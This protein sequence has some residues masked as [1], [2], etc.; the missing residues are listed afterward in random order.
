MLLYCPI[1]KN[2]ETTVDVYNSV[3]HKLWCSKLSC[4]IIKKLFLNTINHRKN[5]A[6]YNAYD[7]SIL[8]VW[9]YAS[10][11]LKMGVEFSCKCEAALVD[12]SICI[13]RMYILPET[14]ALACIM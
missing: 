1:K 3:S 10:T 13:V 12:N 6:K 9:L 7:D 2:S 14:W 4:Q 11:M 5:I 8:Y